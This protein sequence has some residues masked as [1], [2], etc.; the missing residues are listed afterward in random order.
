M[1]PKVPASNSSSARVHLSAAGS[2]LCV[3]PSK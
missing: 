2:Y 1:N 3:I